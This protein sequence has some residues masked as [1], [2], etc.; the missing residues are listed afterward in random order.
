MTQPTPGVPGEVPGEQA[1]RAALEALE[2]T[3][4]E[5]LDAQ[6]AAATALDEALR[7]LLTG[8]DDG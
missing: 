6:I 7:G 5:D 2:R 4:P 1:A 8:T 3:P